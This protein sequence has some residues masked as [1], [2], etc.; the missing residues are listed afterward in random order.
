MMRQARAFTLVELLVVIAII[1]VLV[2][3]LLPAVQA[4]RE[5]ARR[6]QC[7][8]NVKQI[9]LAMHNYHSAHKTLPAGAYCRYL[10]SNTGTNFDNETVF[11]HT[12]LESLMPFLEHQTTWEKLDFRVRPQDVPNVDVLNRFFDPGLVCPSNPD[13]PMM[14][15]GRA[16]GNSG[17]P[18]AY[19]PGAFGTYSLAIS[20]APCGG[21][22]Q[23]NPPCAISPMSP[24]INCKSDRGGALMP[25]NTVPRKSLGA[26]GMFAGGPVSYRFG[27][28]Q[29]GLSKTVLLGERIPA[30]DWTAMYFFSI[31]NAATTNLP[32]NYQLI[33]NMN[34]ANACPRMQTDDLRPAGNNGDCHIPMGGYMSEHPGGINVA[35]SDGSVRFIS[36]EIDYAIYQYLGDKADGHILDSNF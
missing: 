15:N 13:E 32:P 25:P 1:G 16:A 21:P 29:D 19:L 3:L 27:D 14:N 31:M 26:P 24:N 30:Y 10:T 22:L 33:W 34:N 9:A 23:R 5:A 20:Y 6:M 17:S 7:T 35:L 28:C 18:A 2:A 36:D 4:A 12:W 8:N 11:C